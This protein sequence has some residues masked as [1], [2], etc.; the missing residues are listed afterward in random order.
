MELPE[1]PLFEAFV[2]QAFPERRTSALQDLI[3]RPSFGIKPIAPLPTPITAPEQPLRDIVP[4]KYLSEH[5][6]LEM[7]L[8]PRMLFRITE[9]RASR[10]DLP[11]ME[12]KNLLTDA[13]DQPIRGLGPKAEDLI[14]RMERRQRAIWRDQFSGVKSEKVA[15]ILW[16]AVE[17]LIVTGV[18][19]L[20]EGSA[21]ADA[22][23][24]MRPIMAGVFANERWDRSAQRAALRFVQYLQA[25]EYFRPPPNRSSEC[26]R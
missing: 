16:Y 11:I 3:G 9:W 15:A 13:M 6:R 21:L 24:L 4:I 12:I 23:Y 8:F 19:E 7:M 20:E 17:H 10:P 2:K 5:R 25:K 18:V 22:M 26:P 14:Y 1:R